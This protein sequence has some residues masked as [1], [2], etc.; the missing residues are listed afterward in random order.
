MEW[1]LVTAGREGELPSGA[2]HPR[3]SGFSPRVHMPGPASIRSRILLCRETEDCQ[4]P[5][6]LQVMRESQAG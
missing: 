4:D 2:A 3:V 1:G 6:A 5:E